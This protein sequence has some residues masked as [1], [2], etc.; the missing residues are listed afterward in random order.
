MELQ[1]ELNKDN[2]L[3]DH[4]FALAEDAREL[5]RLAVETTIQQR[6]DYIRHMWDNDSE[7]LALELKIIEMLIESQSKAALSV[8]EHGQTKDLATHNTKLEKELLKY[9]Q[10]LLL[11]YQSK[12]GDMEI[13]TI[14]ANLSR[15]FEA[16]VV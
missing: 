3:L 6:D 16:G 7:I 9:K 13:E 5:E 8:Q 12:S 14:E 10:D 2:R 4:Q 15:L 1:H 11:E